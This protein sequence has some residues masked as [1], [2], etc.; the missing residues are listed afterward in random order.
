[1]KLIGIESSSAETL[2]VQNVDFWERSKVV[3]E[4]PIT[5]EAIRIT[6]TAP[7]FILKKQIN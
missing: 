1:M 4:M 2:D 7:P 6:E 5:L 3:M